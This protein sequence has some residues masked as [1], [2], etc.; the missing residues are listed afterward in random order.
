MKKFKFSLES[1]MHYKDALLDK[2][3]NTLL[4]LRA[5][6]TS[7]EQQIERNEKQMLELEADMKQKAMLGTTAMELKTFEFHAENARKLIEQLQTDLA[8]LTALV[9]EQRKVVVA[10][11]QEVSGLEK[12]REK[13]LEEY[14]YGVQKEEE[15]RIGELISSKYAA[16][17]PTQS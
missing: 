7:M 6:Q 11:S 17:N 2:E 10:L 8:N 12:L 1:M 9:E 3:K 4:Q 14:N 15:V 16:E 13:Q 5:T